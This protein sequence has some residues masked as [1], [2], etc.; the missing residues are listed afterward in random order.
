VPQGAPLLSGTIASNL[1]LGDPE[2][3]A[4]VLERAAA[5]AGILSPDA[6]LPDGLVTPV[7]ELGAGLSGGQRARVAIARALVVDPRVLI[8]DE[9]TAA[10]DDE[11]DAVIGSFLRQPSDRA[12]LVIAH[13]PSTIAACDRVIVLEAGRARAGCAPAALLDPS[14]RA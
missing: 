14:R 3:S 7:G 8:L 9:A 13:R 6:G 10:L 4:A 5:H 11:A 1:R 12:T 2:A